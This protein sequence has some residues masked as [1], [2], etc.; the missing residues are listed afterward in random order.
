MLL[1]AEEGLLFFVLS[2]TQMAV[3]AKGQGAG[4]HGAV[5]LCVHQGSDCKGGI[6]GMGTWSTLLP[7]AVPGQN[8]CAHVH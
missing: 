2:C 3:L 4:C 6:A 8:T 7:T 5:G 1:R